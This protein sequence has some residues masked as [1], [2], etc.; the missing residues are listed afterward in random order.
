MHLIDV[1][2]NI[3][4]FSLYAAKLGRK[5]VAVEPFKNNYLRLQKVIL[6]KILEK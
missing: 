3:G 1:G 2:A 6:Q 4:V 5:V